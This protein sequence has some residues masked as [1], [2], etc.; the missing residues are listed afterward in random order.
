MIRQIPGGNLLWTSKERGEGHESASLSQPPLTQHCK[1]H[2][3]PTMMKEHDGK[4]SN[5]GKGGGGQ[6]GEIEAVCY[7][8]RPSRER[9]HQDGELGITAPECGIC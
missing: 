4:R 6:K 1:I 8:Q 5:G 3:L 7:F 2:H 9:E